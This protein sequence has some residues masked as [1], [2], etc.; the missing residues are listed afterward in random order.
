MK[1]EVKVED[2][3]VDVTEEEY[4][5]D[6]ARGLEEDEVLKPG[7]HRFKRGGF[8]ARH[9]LQPGQASAPAKVRISI[10]LDEDVLNHFKQRAARPNAAPYQTQINKALREVMERE[11]Q[12]SSTSL[13]PQ[14]VELLADQ[15][16]IEAVAEQVRARGL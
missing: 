1:E 6:L 3:I 15:R 10:N 7:R 11:Q 16:F 13:S 12:T 4:Q 8:L 2:I 9:G 14:A 5:T